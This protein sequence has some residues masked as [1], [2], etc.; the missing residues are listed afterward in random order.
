M[1]LVRRA[2]FAVQALLFLSLSGVQG[3]RAAMPKAP[4][5]DA[6]APAIESLDSQLFD[7]FNHCRL[8]AFAALLAEDIEF[9]HDIGGL[10]RS[11]HDV[12]ES[13]KNNICG[14][15]TRELVPGTLEVYPIPGYG[16]VELGVHRFHH[17]GHED[18]EPVGEGRFV[19]IWHQTGDGWKLS[20][21]ISFAH[22]ALA[23]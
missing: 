5:N 9:Y 17:P 20:R 12:V 22:H 18:V 16:A 7:A 4:A 2:S 13:V 6:L 3:G 21:V 15:V 23:R 1:S 11:R 8:D 10:S 14:K 19:H